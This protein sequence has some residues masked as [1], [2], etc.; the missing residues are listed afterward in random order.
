MSAAFKYLSN[1]QQKH[2][3]VREIMYP[4]LQTQPYIVN[5]FFKNDEVNLLYALRSRMVN[6]KAN[7]SSKYGNNLICPLC[8]GSVDDQ[9]HVLECVELLSNPKTEELSF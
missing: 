5:P 2:S 3:K 6:V 1:K 9:Q 7:F 8:E 4:K